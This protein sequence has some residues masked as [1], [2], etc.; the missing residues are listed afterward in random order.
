MYLFE[1]EH[2][3]G[4]RGRSR[5]PRSTWGSVLGR[6]DHDLSRRQ[7]FSQ[8]SHPHAPEKFKCTAK[9]KGKP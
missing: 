8:L 3:M 9:L 7:T 6:R 4:V 2:K 1:K 5:L